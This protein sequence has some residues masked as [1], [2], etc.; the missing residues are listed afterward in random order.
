M[1]LRNESTWCSPWKDAIGLCGDDHLE[2]E[3]CLHWRISTFSTAAWV[4][5][6]SSL[7]EEA[8]LWYGNYRGRH[9]RKN[10]VVVLDAELVSVTVASVRSF[11]R[12]AC[13]FCCDSTHWSRKRYCNSS[14][15]GVDG[16]DHQMNETS[17]SEARCTCKECQRP[18]RRG[19]SAPSLPARRREWRL[20]SWYH[21]QFYGETWMNPSVSMVSKKWLPEIRLAFRGCQAGF[22]RCFVQSSIIANEFEVG[23]RCTFGLRWME[24]S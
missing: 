18:C 20:S 16:L 7:D 8:T 21:A 19:T 3:G 10:R 1:S 2:N 6:G 5:R 12:E 17:R 22:E 23:I 13:L 14:A 24:E 11:F 9:P 4:R 15:T